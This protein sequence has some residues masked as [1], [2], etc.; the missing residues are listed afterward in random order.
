MYRM[1]VFGYKQY[2]QS[3]YSERLCFVIIM[4]AGDPLESRRVTMCG[5][6]HSTSANHR[7]Y[8]G[9]EETKKCNHEGQCKASSMKGDVRKL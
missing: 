4:S 7:Q 1:Y 9:E 8:I 5:E 3:N 6:S 2:F